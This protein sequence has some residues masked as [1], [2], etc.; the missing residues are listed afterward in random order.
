ME[1]VEKIQGAK[2]GRPGYINENCWLVKNLNYSPYNRCQHCDQKFRNCL[3]LH[4]QTISLALILFLL[5]LSFLIEGKI[6][7][8]III[9]VFTLVI[10]YGYFFNKST[11][12]IIKANFAQREAKEALEELTK[13][14]QKK[15]DEQTKEIR[16]AY[17]VEKGARMELEALGNAKN[18]FMLAIQHHLR[19]PLTSM[20]GYVDLLL[21][22]AYGKQPKKTKDV[23][24]KFK[25][26][27]GKL[28]KMVNEFLDITQFQLGKKVVSLRPGVEILPILDDIVKDL[29][30]EAE[31][32][33]IYI[34]LNKP[35]KTYIIEADP[36]KLK[37]ALF[38]LFD[39]AIKYTQEGGVNIKLQDKD[40]KLQIEI[41]DTGIGISQ[42]NI[43][44]LFGRTFER[45][46]IAKRTFATGRGI[47]LYISSQ[48]IQAHN[49]KV[50]VES[51]GEGKGSTFHIEFPVEEK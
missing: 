2:I 13:N 49:G 28:I 20:N 41:K 45:S 16:K 18:Q 23:I 35:E 46:D 22:G 48:I 21:S 11:D 40:G 19:T 51:E 39:N 44:N 47:G 34:K 12:K 27:T 15:V 36:E 7:K 6:S 1:K 5:V 42:E 30:F 31:S 9:S 29:V 33:G 17:D 38:N 26:S 14:L 50:W 37:L 24:E 3:F 10:V 8:L 25:N 32:K 43:K 4:Y